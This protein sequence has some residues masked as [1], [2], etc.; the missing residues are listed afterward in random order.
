MIDQEP[1]NNSSDSLELYADQEGVKHIQKILAAVEDEP[2]G[3]TLLQL[4]WTAGPLTFIALQGGY[5]IGY[6]KVAPFDLFVYFAG[7]TLLT[8]LIGFVIKAFYNAHYKTKYEQTKS[9]YLASN[10]LLFRLFR[11]VSDH[12]LSE[13][14]KIER[15]AESS[16]ILLSNTHALPASIAL[17]VNE[18]TNNDTLIKLIEKIELFRRSG[19]FSRINDLIEK[20]EVLKDDE[21]LQLV[22]TPNKAGYYLKMR[23]QGNA[24]TLQE[25]IARED[26][27]LQRINQASENNQPPMLHLRDAEEF[28]IL[29]YELLNGRRIS[30][31]TFSYTNHKKLRYTARTLEK[32]R[33]TFRL[34]RASLLSKIDE[35]YSK[36]INFELITDVKDYDTRVKCEQ[37]F[38]SLND[39]AAQLLVDLNNRADSDVKNKRTVFSN[40]VHLYTKI[41]KLYK[42]TITHQKYLE[43]AVQNWRSLSNQYSEKKTRFR[44]GLGKKG[45]RINQKEICLDDETKLNFSNAIID[46]LRCYWENYVCTSNITSINVKQLIIDL[47]RQLDQFIN[48]TNPINQYGIESSN[49]TN[50]G[51][52]ELDSSIEARALWSASMVAETK[53]DIHQAA[54]KLAKVLLYEYDETLDEKAITFLKEKYGVNP[55]SLLKMIDEKTHSNYRPVQDVPVQ[56]DAKPQTWTHVL[57]KARK[58]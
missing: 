44:Y 46:T 29:L 39:Y 17:G 12:R 21:T 52:L 47:S 6:G 9:N 8:G 26:G 57:K 48:I 24:P 35:L 20:S 27:F 25:G 10:D 32:S 40:L 4:A 13:L 16:S 31:L 22:N 38:A 43:Q 18:L 19:L 2:W 42:E 23:L 7:Y 1:E 30:F 55:S 56:L 54:Q 53:N 58:I 3:V 5:L 34:S 36:M 33:A 41:L 15:K 37:I 14:P 11:K 28:L 49:A 51:S 50:F 45:L